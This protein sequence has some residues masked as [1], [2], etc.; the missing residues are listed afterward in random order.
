MRIVKSL[1]FTV[2]LMFGSVANANIMLW[3][4]PAVQS[5]TVT[6]DDIS[7][8]IMISGLGDHSPLSLGSFDLDVLFDASQLSFTG[9]NLFDGL[10]DINLSDAFD[11]SGGEYLP[12]V[13]NLYESSN[14]AA[15]DLDSLQAGTFA[16]AE[17]FFHVDALSSGESSWLSLVGNSFG[18]TE[19]LYLDV[20]IGDDAVIS[21]PTPAPLAL[22]GIALLSMFVRLNKNRPI[23]NKLPN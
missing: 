12:G 1:V 6:G 19:G 23:Y 3:L 13:I 8:K 5:N 21:A 20:N 11:F 10:G 15:F 22:L 7:L 18:D 16:L 14:L 4:D 9:Y 2:A 17:L